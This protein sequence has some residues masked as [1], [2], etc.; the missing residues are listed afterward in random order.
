MDGELFEAMTG[1]LGEDSL[2][3]GRVVFD[4]AER[5]DTEA[6]DPVCGTRVPGVFGPTAKFKGQTFRFCSETCRQIFIKD[7][8]RFAK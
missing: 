3:E 6:R 4:R 1:K 5:S 7:P 2:D 8:V